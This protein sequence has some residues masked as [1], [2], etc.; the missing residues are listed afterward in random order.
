MTRFVTAKR[1]AA[2]ATATAAAALALVAGSSA[3]SVAAQG[4]AATPPSLTLDFSAN[5]DEANVANGVGAGFGGS[6][7]VTDASGAPAGTA[8]DMCDKDAISLK[9]VTAFCH[10][11]VVFNDGSQIALSVVFPIQD[12]LTATYPKSFDGVITGGTGAYQGLTG[13]AH[14]TNTA[15]AVYTVTWDV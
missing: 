6:A 11:D 5:N 4:E 9:Q 2:A 1:A 8:Y 7:T 10:A 14:F 3:P 15:L 13:A 12:P